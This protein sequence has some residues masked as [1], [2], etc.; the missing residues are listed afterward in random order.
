[1]PGQKEFDA[2]EIVASLNT[3]VGEDIQKTAL[4][5]L[6]N[7]VV[8]TPVGD[9]TLWQIPV[10][11]PGYVGGHARRNWMVSI[12]SPLSASR[13]VPGRGGGKADATQ[14]ALK[15]GKGRIANFDP[16]SDSRIIIQN[17]VPYIVRL[18]NGHSEQAPANFV[19]TAVMAGRNVGR[20]D[21]KE[22]P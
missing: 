18:N 13:G 10:A 6:R 17:N 15:Q 8:G 16:E 11:P 4:A 12:G 9:P 20:N 19:Q 21:R 2:L 14:R 3:E 5:V 22:L 7:V 1:M